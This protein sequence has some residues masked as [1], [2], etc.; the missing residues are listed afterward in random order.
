VC[1]FTISSSL[2]FAASA[3]FAKIRSITGS[4]G[5][6]FFI[7]EQPKFAQV[8]RDFAPHHG[9]QRAPF[10]IRRSARLDPELEAFFSFL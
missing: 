7:F 3:L 9:P 8:I 4:S 6:R 5:G 1:A 2:L 10:S